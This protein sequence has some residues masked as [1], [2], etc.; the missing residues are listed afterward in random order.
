MKSRLCHIC[1]LLI[2]TLTLLSLCKVT[3]GVFLCFYVIIQSTVN[4]WSMLCRQHSAPNVRPLWGYK[5]LVFFP[6]VQPSYYSSVHYSVGVY[7]LHR[8]RSVRYS[9]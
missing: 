5:A 7:R 9:V 2:N 4:G 1:N 6:V 8:K 3:D